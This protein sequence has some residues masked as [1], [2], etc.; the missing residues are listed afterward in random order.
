M[1]VCVRISA[2]GFI[3][4]CYS[5]TLFVLAILR[6][7]HSL[8][9]LGAYVLSG[10]M[11]VSWCSV[12]LPRITL[13][14]SQFYIRELVAVSEPMKRN[15]SFQWLLARLVQ[16][17]PPTTPKFNWK[18][19]LQGGAVLRTAAETN[20][21]HKVE[22]DYRCCSCVWTKCHRTEVI[23]KSGIGV[24][25]T[26]ICQAVC[27]ACNM[28]FWCD[29]RPSNTKKTNRKVKLPNIMR[30]WNQIKSE[31]IMFNIGANNM[32]TKKIR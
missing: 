23:S 29:F 27:R 17:T 5:A 20:H 15:V 7:S 10:L 9:Q 30:F 26:Y 19:R 4:F 13:A 1:M 6:I 25:R 21:Y 8:G 24:A 28:P 12:F 16:T 22:S 11:V 32:S 14:T 31:T 18:R 3:Y 2:A